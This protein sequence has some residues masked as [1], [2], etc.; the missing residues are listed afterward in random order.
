MS[1]RLCLL[2]LLLPSITF[3]LKGKKLQ[4]ENSI[5]TSRLSSY[6]ETDLYPSIR[7]LLR[8]QTWKLFLFVTNWLL[9]QSIFPNLFFSIWFL[10]LFVCI[11]VSPNKVSVIAQ[12]AYR[13]QVVLLNSWELPWLTYAQCMCDVVKSCIRWEQRQRTSDQLTGTISGPLKR[14]SANWLTPTHSSSSRPFVF[15]VFSSSS[16]KV[17]REEGRKQGRVRCCGFYNARIL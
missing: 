1:P 16:S 15:V 5:G 8:S 9:V 17:L 7:R 13:S 12:E 11:C 3:S 14:Y 4:R 6:L 10:F 2:S